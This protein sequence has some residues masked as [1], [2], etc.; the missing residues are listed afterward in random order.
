MTSQPLVSTWGQMPA[1]GRLMGV[2]YGTVRIGLAVSDRE[3]SLAS[4]IA[5][6]RSRS[7]EHDRGEYRKLIDKWEPVALVVGL[8]LHVSGDESKMS[9]RA[10][11]HAA[12]LHATFKLP[13]TVADERFTSQ[14]AEASLYEMDATNA[15][16]KGRIDGIAATYMLQG[17]LDRQRASQQ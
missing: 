14:E 12:W 15:Q 5:M 3:Q 2:D 7:D 6:F 1:R 16:R 13:C 4:P 9:A 17:Y 10:R 11:Q 8:P